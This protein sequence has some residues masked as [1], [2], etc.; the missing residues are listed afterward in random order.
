MY[1]MLLCCTGCHGYL[2]ILRLHRL[3]SP[4]SPGLALMSQHPLHMFFQGVCR[5]NKKKHPPPY[6]FNFLPL[7]S[8]LALPLPP[9]SA[10]LFPS[11]IYNPLSLFLLLSFAFLTIPPSHSHVLSLSS[12]F[13]PLPLA[14]PPSPIFLLPLSLRSNELTLLTTLW[15]T[16]LG[17]WVHF[18]FTARRTNFNSE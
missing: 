18:P 3:R 12:R 1:C 7:H 2:A 9:P 17:S 5:T 10:W 15:L 6:M 11:H 4:W 14:L 16:L 8:F 13:P